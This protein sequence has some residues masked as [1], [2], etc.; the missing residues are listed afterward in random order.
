MA[1]VE[2]AAP[3]LEA[4]G[5]EAGGLGGLGGM[6]GMLKDFNDNP[7]TK[8]V[9]STAGKLVHELVGSIG[10]GG[11]DRERANIGPIGAIG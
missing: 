2:A 5:G 11:G 10:T 6:G 7:V 4:G 9:G 8:I 1:F 3:L